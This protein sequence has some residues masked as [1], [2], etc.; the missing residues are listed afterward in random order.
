MV[1][2]LNKSI[3]VVA[4]MAMLGHV[5]RNM[6]IPRDYPEVVVFQ[7]DQNYLD[8]NLYITTLEG[9]TQLG[10]AVKQFI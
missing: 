8:Y 1:N 7:F 2:N 3:Q 10:Q 4:G 5:F 6:L 9:V